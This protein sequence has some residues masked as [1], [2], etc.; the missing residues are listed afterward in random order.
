MNCSQRFVTV[1]LASLAV[2]VLGLGLSAGAASPVPIDGL[3]LWLKA[4]E[5]V[6]VGADNVVTRWIDQS[7]CGNH[8]TTEP[9][10][11]PALVTDYLNGK[12]VLQFDGK[13]TYLVVK[14]TDAL[15]AGIE[16]SSFA[17]YRFDTG[18]RVL[19]KKNKSGAESDAWFMGTREGLSV[20][21]IFSRE[22][23]FPSRTTDFQ[24][25]SG[26]FD[27]RG[28]KIEIYRNGTLVETLTKGITPQMANEDDVFIGKREH[29]DKAHLEGHIAEVLI[30]NR[31]V[32]AAEREQIEK[33]LLDK[34]ALN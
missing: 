13:N 6:E 27:A 7:G 1:I 34:Y 22:L 5:G 33:Y 20:G 32:S 14:H 18:I 31:A 25:Q 26:I 24:L 9:G 12:P 29:T 17:V 23:L 8:A 19:Q 21:G 4:D 28:R 3:Q 2:V 16:F 11:G 15:N 30:Y 10:S